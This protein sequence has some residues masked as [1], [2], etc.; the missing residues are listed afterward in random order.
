MGDILFDLKAPVYDWM[1]KLLPQCQSK[2][3]AIEGIDIGQLNVLVTY[4]S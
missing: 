1:L 2:V 3:R 4:A